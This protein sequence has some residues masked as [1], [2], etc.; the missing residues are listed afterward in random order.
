MSTYLTRYKTRIA[1]LGILFLLLSQTLAL[2]HST[3]HYFHEADTLCDIYKSVQHSP[4]GIIT[5]PLIV[6]TPRLTDDVNAAR[7]TAP[8]SQYHQAYHSRAPPLV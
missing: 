6:I 3:E 5:N 8:S 2:L 4:S 7:I 1:I